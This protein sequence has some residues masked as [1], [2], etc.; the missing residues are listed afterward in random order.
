M[1]EVVE[2]ILSSAE[3]SGAK[4]KASGTKAY[5][6]VSGKKVGKLTKGNLDDGFNFQLRTDI[7]KLKL[8]TANWKGKGRRYNWSGRPAKL[9]KTLRIAVTRLKKS[10]EKD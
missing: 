5:V 1:S 7:K 10:L 8:K 4:I 9:G 2:E 6:Y 3:K